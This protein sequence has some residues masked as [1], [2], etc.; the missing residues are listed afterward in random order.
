MKNTHVISFDWGS[1]Q[2]YTT[3]SLGELACMIIKEEV[4]TFLRYIGTKESEI[5]V[6]MKLVGCI[7]PLEQ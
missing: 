7:Y 6:N 1:V 2:I 5:V 3:R 4:H